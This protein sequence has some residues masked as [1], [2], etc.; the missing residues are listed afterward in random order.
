MSLSKSLVL[1]AVIA[2]R[3]ASSPVD[4]VGEGGVV[5]QDAQSLASTCAMWGGRGYKLK[6]HY[7]GGDVRWHRTFEY[8]DASGSLKVDD[9]D[10]KLVVTRHALT[11]TPQQRDELSQALSNVCPTSDDLAVRCAPGGCVRVEVTTSDGKSTLV[12]SW[13][14]SETIANRLKKYFPQLSS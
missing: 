4:G 7:Q 3:P 5:V 1:V 2:C 13:A 9:G 8:D 6:Y 11:L 12:E 14:G 10:T